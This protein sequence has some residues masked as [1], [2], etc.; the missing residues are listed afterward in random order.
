S[1][2]RAE[3][4]A[5]GS[6]LL[7][8]ADRDLYGAVAERIAVVEL[9]KGGRHGEIDAA[10]VRERYGV[11][12]EQVPDF[13][14]LR[15]DPS[16]GLPGGPGSAARPAAA[17]VRAQGPLEPLPAAAG[18][19]TAAARSPAG[20]ALKPRAAHA[21]RENAELLKAFKQVATLQTVKV[22]RPA[23]RKA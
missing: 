7:L 6:A 15:G 4:A 20:S 1:Y 17:L 18:A 9:L 13:I 23:Q 10:G 2:A 12:P 16:A 21:L 19:G 5:G 22:K 14:A 8:T 11:E 3:A